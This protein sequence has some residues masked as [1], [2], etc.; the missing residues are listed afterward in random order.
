MRKLLKSSRWVVSGAAL[1]AIGGCVNN[2]QMLDFMRTEFARV[3]ADVA[4]Q[5][6]QLVVQGSL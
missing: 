5:A 2:Q 6:F 4:G 3:V 1:L